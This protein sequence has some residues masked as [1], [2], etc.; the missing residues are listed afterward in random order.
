MSTDLKER[1]KARLFEVISAQI[2]AI[3]Y[4][5]EDIEKLVGRQDLG[6]DGSQLNASGG[7]HDGRPAPTGTEAAVAHLAG[8]INAH[9]DAA[10]YSRDELM[11][12]LHGDTEY[13]NIGYWDATTKTQDEA[14]VRLQDT[15]L[16]YIPEKTGRILDVACGKGASTRRLL[17]HFPA[18]NIWAINISEKQIESTRQN[19]P[20]CHAMVMNAVDLRFEDE[21]FDNILCIEAAFHFETRRRFLEEALRVLKP[22]GRLVLSDVLFTSRRRLE[23]YSVFPSPENHLASVDEYRTLLAEVGYRT[24][25]IEDARRDIWSGHFL[26]V[27]NRVHELMQTGE[28][29]IIQATRILWTYYH[30]DAITGPCLFVCAQK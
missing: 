1:L 9:Y 18:T 5:P 23:Q 17:Q 6:Q 20:G 4:V 22:G 7:D 3:G 21:Y 28:M 27:A 30:L 29:D 14:S 15:L 8:T 24:C 11:W 25:V 12:V 2:D 10:F 16:R 19:A 13:K 26:H